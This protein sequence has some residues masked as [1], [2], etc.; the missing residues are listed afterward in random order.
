MQYMR[1]LFV[2][3][4]PEKDVPEKMSGL[5][6]DTKIQ[7]ERRKK[8]PRIL[9]L[10]G[11]DVTKVCFGAP[12]ISCQTTAYNRTLDLRRSPHSSTPLSLWVQSAI[13]V[14]LLLH[15]RQICGS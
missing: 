8:G 3:E 15:L 13:S 5:L 11:S 7:S 9:G 4:E 6:K 1:A 10:S 2:S 14:T 12:K